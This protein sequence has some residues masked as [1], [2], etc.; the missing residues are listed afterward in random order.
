MSERNI[1]KRLR[2]AIPVM[3]CKSGCHDCC[4]PIMFSKWERNR[5][6]KL[7]VSVVDCPYLKNDGCSIYDER[8]I[9]C[10]LFG[11]TVEVPQIMC[12]HGCK[13]S[14]PLTKIEAGNIMS[15]YL[16]LFPF[17]KDENGQM[18]HG[19]NVKDGDYAYG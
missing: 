11:A 16:T 9:I 7:K 3:N 14:K 15:E 12:P 17:I 18:V 6:P 10:R 2:K 4:G 19:I 1:I 13:P 8:P 5:V